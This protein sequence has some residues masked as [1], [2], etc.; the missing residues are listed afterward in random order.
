MKRRTSLTLAL[1][2]GMVCGLT[3]CMR[4]IERTYSGPNNIT[5]TT[6]N[7]PLPDEAFKAQLDSPFSFPRSLKAGQR[8]NLN[9]VV[10]NQSNH[11]WPSGSG[12][13][14]QYRI[15]VGNHW[16]NEK[17]TTVVLDDARSSLPYDLLSG[18]KAEVL[19]TINAPDNA[20]NYLLEVDVVQ[21]KVSWFASK[22]S[23]TLRLNVAVE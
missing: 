9:V 6:I 1:L 20:G 23:R 2:V 11:T 12:A 8:A 22:G 16:L 21:E 5:H 14:G 17:G 18:Q 10:M 4:V 15:A 13:D 7:D 19:L 3:A